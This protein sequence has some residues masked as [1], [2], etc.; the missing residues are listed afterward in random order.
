M[1]RWLSL[2]ALIAGVAAAEADPGSIRGAVIDAGSGEPIPGALVR[3]GGASALT[4]ARGRFSIAAAP[5]DQLVISAAAHTA[6]TVEVTGATLEIALEPRAA[7]EGEVIEIIPEEPPDP[8]AGRPPSYELT[9]EVIRRVPGAGNDAL[10]SLQALPGVGRVPFGVGGLVLRGTSPRD[11]R[12]YIEGIE[13]PLLYHFAGL[14]SFVPSTLLDSLELIG[15]GY[16][17]ELGRGQG[18]VAVLGWRPGR[19]DRW[20]IGSEL[21]M[22]DLSLRAD[23]PTGDHSAWSFALRRSVV[24]AVLPLIAS[25]AD[26]GLTT[27]P[28]Y[29]DG[30]LRYDLDRPWSG[31]RL[32]FLVLGSDDQMSVEY[33]ENQ[34]KRFTLEARFARVGVSWDQRLGALT[35][36]RVVPWI[37]LERYHL[38]STFQTMTSSNTPAGLRARVVR[39]IGLGEV[40]AGIDVAGGDFSAE[41]LTV[42]DDDDAEIAISGA[43]SYLDAAAWVELVA[44]FARG[45]LNVKPGLRVDRFGLAGAFT[46]DPRLVVTHELGRFEI[47]ESAGVFHQSP[48]PADSLWGNDDLEPSYAI[49]ST[50]G[51]DVALSDA[52]HIGVTGFYSELYNL[53][54]DDPA[55]DDEALS[56]FDTYK[57]GAI[58]STREFLAKQFGTFSQLINA[59]RG[60]NIG[61]ELLARHAGPRGFAWIAYTLSS[62]RR[63]DGPGLA[64]HPYILDQ[65]HLLTALGSLRL[66]DSWRVGARIRIATGNPITPVIGA[67]MIGPEEFEPIYGPELSERLPLFVQLDV[68]LDRAWRRDWGTIRA[69]IDVQNVTNRD[70]IEGRVYADDYSSFETTKGLPL[71]PSFGVEYAPPIDH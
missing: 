18:G 30:Q 11:S 68:R 40:R 5:G 67:D 16:S 27:A 43:D 41:S 64:E 3:G 39:V 47:R 50:L 52:T 59:G 31:A 55:A 8:H 1:S 4:D 63:R 44:R 32:A 71:F 57:I 60:R 24:D 36:L 25:D 53:A 42:D 62:S 46:A 54:V 51:V 23:G 70:N 58:A 28:R 10:K 12:V 19:T 21:S 69:F 15:G 37:G 33:G 49:Q 29:W 22:F 7:A 66:G 13:V 45:R 38:A 6:V 34:D 61:L 65:R 35:D 56:D 14:A 17:A 20:R 26:V 48:T 2:L 9:P